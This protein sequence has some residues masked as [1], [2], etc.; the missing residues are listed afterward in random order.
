MQQVRASCLSTPPGCRETFIFDIAEE[1][2][3]EDF[4]LDEQ[5]VLMIAATGFEDGVQVFAMDATDGDDDWVYSPCAERCHEK[6]QM[7]KASLP[8]SKT[9]EAEVVVDSGADVSVA[10]LAYREY[11]KESALAQRPDAGRPG[12][13][14]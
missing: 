12:Q 2:D 8:G 4:S 9:F 6:I 13:A 3:L 10:P 14:H 5:S 1:G 11:G 7:V